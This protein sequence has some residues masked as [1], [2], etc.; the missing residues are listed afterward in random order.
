MQS[1]QIDITWGKLIHGEGRPGM[2]SGVEY[3]GIGTQKSNQ[4][5][6]VLLHAWLSEAFTDLPDGV[7]PASVA[8]L[9]LGR[10]AA[11]QSMYRAK[12]R[13]KGANKVT[14]KELRKLLLTQSEVQQLFQ[15][16]QVCSTSACTAHRSVSS[17]IVKCLREHCAVPCNAFRSVASAVTFFPSL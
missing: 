9:K 1:I 8:A 14:A 7:A 13:G 11:L 12:G 15:S 3:A 16:D 4:H 5:T 10:I 6:A 17:V 2:D